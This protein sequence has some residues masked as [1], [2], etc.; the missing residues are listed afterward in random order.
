LIPDSSAGEKGGPAGRS[1]WLSTAGLLGL[2]PPGRVALWI[3]R[4]LAQGQF[5]L[6][7]D[8]SQ[9]QY[10][11]WQAD[12]AHGAWA[13]Y[14]QFAPAGRERFRVLDVA[15]GG[16]GRLGV[17]AA[18]DRARFF[19]VDNQIELLRVARRHLRENE[20]SRTVTVAAADAAVLPF[21]DAS[22]DLCLCE[23]G[24]EHFADVR[25]VVTEMVRVLRPGGHLVVLFPPWRGAYSGHLRRVTWLPWIHL[26]PEAL[27]I[28]VVAAIAAADP[29]SD[30]RAA[31]DSIL[32]GVAEGLNGC[33]LPD[34]LR[35]F[36]DAGEL[37]PASAHVLGWSGLHLDLLPF[38]GEF[39]ASAVYLA[40]RKD[41]A[42]GRQPVS[43]Y[44]GVLALAVGASLRRRIVG[45]RKRDSSG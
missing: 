17:H 34:V 40:Y 27:L 16:G 14:R 35:A 9:D 11:Q 25:R 43:S 10:L 31:A 26:L 13:Y 30:W 33:R 2:R 20:G 22:F 28:R 1:P 45:L 5:R 6:T 32:R 19:A 8:A 29:R 24:I 4:L 36:R 42:G 38:V 15:T 44:Q 37:A 41:A 21:S 12:S 39:F 3:G 18:D 7:A 23:N